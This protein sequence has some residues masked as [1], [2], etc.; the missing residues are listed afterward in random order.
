MI[1]TSKDSIVT[2]GVLVRSEAPIEYLADPIT[3]QTTISLGRVE[4]VFDEASLD[5]LADVVQAARRELES[6]RDKPR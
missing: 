3:G 6:T 4:L 1:S 5:R 2:V